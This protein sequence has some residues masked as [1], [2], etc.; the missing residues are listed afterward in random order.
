M[1]I[2]KLRQLAN[3][4]DERALGTQLI[5][6]YSLILRRAYRLDIERERVCDLMSGRMSDVVKAD[7]PKKAPFGLIHH[8]GYV[9]QIDTHAAEQVQPAAR[10][11]QACEGLARRQSLK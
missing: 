1:G 10:L 7:A 11:A 6:Q 3:V 2:E 4:G 9:L 8:Q 5:R